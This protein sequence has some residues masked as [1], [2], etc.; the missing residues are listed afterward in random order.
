[1][2]GWIFK[3]CSRFLYSVVFL[4]FAACFAPANASVCFLPD[5]DNCGTNDIVTQCDGIRFFTKTGS[6]TCEKIKHPKSQ[7]CV[8][9]GDC[10]ELKCIYSGQSECESE[11][12]RLS[13][14]Y[15]HY[16]CELDE[17][18]GCWQLKWT[19]CSESTSYSGCSGY[20][21]TSPED[22]KACD[23]CSQTVTNNLC[24]N[25]GISYTEYDTR[26]VYDCVP[27]STDVRGCSGYNLSSPI[28]GYDCDSCTPDVY[29]T[30]YS[31]NYNYSGKGNTVYSCSKTAG[32]SG[33]DLTA[34]DKDTK[35]ASGDYR[36][37]ECTPT[38]TDDSG[39]TTNGTTVY[40]CGKITTSTTSCPANYIS[41][42]EADELK[43]DTCYSCTGCTPTTDYYEDGVWYN[44]TSGTTVYNCSKPD[45]T[46]KSK[47]SD[48]GTG[49]EFVAAGDCAKF[50]NGEPCGSCIDCNDETNPIN[51][52]FGK[53]TCKENG[54]H[55]V[56]AVTCTCGNVPYYDRC[57]V[58]ETC[59]TNSSGANG[60]YCYA[61]T[62]ASWRINHGDYVVS[63]KCKKIDLTPV[64]YTADCTT[65]K[66]CLGNPGAA[67]GKKT[68]KNDEGADG[69][70]SVE[71]G[72]YKYFSA[73]KETCNTNSSGANGGYCGATT[74]TSWRINHGDYVVSEKC[75]QDDGTKVYYTAD[76]TTDKDCTGNPGPAYGKKTCKNDEG[77]DGATSVECGGYKYFSACKETCNTNS[78]GANGGYCGATT[79]TSWRINHGDY[80]VSE[81]CEQDDGTK[82]YYTADCTTDKDCTGNPGPAYGKKTCSSNQYPGGDTVECGGYTYADYCM[83]ECNYEDDAKSCADK[84]KTFVAKC[85]DKNDKEWGECKDKE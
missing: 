3:A 42:A 74:D 48:C 22:G 77:A 56:G 60:G 38:V 20:N 79:D 8:S 52:C 51:K 71:C 83:G 1:M 85:H 55:G 21:L 75:E 50:A 27:I 35:E 62:D 57:E 44:G 37:H 14:K 4:G 9:V 13:Y 12:D 82:V 66:D 19:D 33:Y 30:D 70:T 58:E 26:T 40:K 23:S 84:G 68:C 80:V 43:K 45:C 7:T 36:C 29:K 53:Y 11:A 18:V 25:K 61:T 10:D 49:K 6:V 34:S 63:E 69:A 67:Y 81:K 32:C 24:T 73:C 54:R 5:A 76:C 39:N 41:A 64:Y 28:S 47:A 72:G 17:S 15:R 65:D 2:S 78:S 31:G 46:N 16:E 59:N